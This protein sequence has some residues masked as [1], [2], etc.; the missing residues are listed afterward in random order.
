MKT[1]LIDLGG[2]IVAAKMRVGRKYVVVKNILW[3]TTFSRPIITIIT[4]KNSSS[5]IN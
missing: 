4:P 3:F 5:K 2:T 1:I